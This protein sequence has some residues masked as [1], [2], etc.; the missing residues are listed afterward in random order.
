[1]AIDPEEAKRIED[2]LVHDADD[3]EI[4]E[5]RGIYLT[6]RF[7]SKAT[8]VVYGFLLAVSL[9]LHVLMRGG[10]LIPISLNAE[11]VL[12]G[13]PIAIGAIFFYLNAGPYP[14]QV[15]APKRTWAGRA[16]VLGITFVV[17]QVVSVLLW[18]G[19]AKA[20]SLQ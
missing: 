4:P 15:V 11:A 18:L 16:V 5:G 3:D 20:F 9:L 12:M 13:L 14:D 17:V 6:A 10:A 1:M 8:L 7:L 2:S 19:L